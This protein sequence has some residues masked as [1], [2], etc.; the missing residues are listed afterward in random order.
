MEAERD[1]F[2]LKVMRYIEQENITSFTGFITGFKY[3]RVF[4][5]IE[6]MPTEAVVEAH[7]LTNEKELLLTDKF[8]AFIK[9]LGRP[10]LLGEEWQ[11]ELDR[12]DTE[13]MRIFCRPAFGNA[14]R[15]NQKGRTGPRRTHDK[16]KRH[17]RKK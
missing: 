16:S 9:R 8:S 15:E 17:R 14:P 10:A 7:H 5:E 2:R 4:L 13:A 1:I 3:D 6:G 12:L 11:L